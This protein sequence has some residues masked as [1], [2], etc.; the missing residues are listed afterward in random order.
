MPIDFVS[1]RPFILYDDTLELPPEPT[2]TG[3]VF[4][5][6]SMAVFFEIF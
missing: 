5:D 3:A 2:L 6:K 1:C 4:D